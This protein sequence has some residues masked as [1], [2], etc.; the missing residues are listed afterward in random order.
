[1]PTAESIKSA[2]KS[3]LLEV[4]VSRREFLSHG[5]SLSSL[6]IHVRVDCPYLSTCFESVAKDHIHN[7]CR[8]LTL[9]HAEGTPAKIE[10]DPELYCVL[11]GRG[12][13][14][15][16]SSV[17]NGELRSLD[18]EKLLIDQF[19]DAVDFGCIADEMRSQAVSLNSTGLALIARLI[20]DKL[21][22][23]HL[24]GHRRPIKRGSRLI[25]ETWAFNY[26]NN[27]T[28]LAELNSIRDAFN[29]ISKEAGIGLGVAFDDYITAAANLRYDREKIP[30]RTVFGKGGHLEVHCFKDK[31]EYR[32]SQ[33]AFDAL[34]A[35]LTLN[36]E[37]D[38]V[39]A[40]MEKTDL[41]ETAK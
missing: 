13:R 32:F 26:F 27:H 28:V 19:L 17:D 18:D 29:R 39:V 38:V 12:T 6:G 25:C 35:F 8:E 14:R 41:L 1:M 20:V 33:P 3:K 23:A 37:F 15:A 24:N 4:L 9:R 34:I 2:I 30:S 31:H 7:L 22:L 5:N 11:T 16:F 40:I 10:I 36:G 21:N